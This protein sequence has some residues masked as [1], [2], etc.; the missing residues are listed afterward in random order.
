LPGGPEKD[1]RRLKGEGMNRYLLIGGIALAV[2]LGTFVYV[3]DTFTYLGHNPT[4]CANCHVMDSA[5]E[6]WYHGAHARA[7]VCTDCHA[8]NDNPI[9]YYYIKTKLGMRDVYSFSTGQIPVAIRADK[10]TD[11]ILQA[12]C[13]RCHATRVES[14]LVYGQPYDRKCWDCHRTTAHSER[15]L[16]ILPRE[17]LSWQE[18]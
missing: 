13:I 9:S 3:T 5:Y 11:D 14:M 2:A 17:D 12:N 16:S 8:P 6:T 1:R 7:T 15:G 18:K 10:E 4:N